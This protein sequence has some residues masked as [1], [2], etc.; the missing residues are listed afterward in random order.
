MA[1]VQKMCFFAKKTK[2]MK[3]NFLPLAILLITGILIS[4]CQNEQTSNNHLYP[5][6]SAMLIYKNTSGKM[7]LGYDT[8]YFDNYG[9]IEVQIRHSPQGREKIIRNKTKIYDVNYKNQIVLYN[10]IQLQPGKNLEESLSITDLLNNDST[11]HKIGTEKILN[12]KCDIY[13]DSTGMIK[14]YVWKNL[15]LKQEQSF[16]NM[17]IT[18]EVIK[19]EKNI[20]FPKGL[21]DYP[22]NFK[23]IDLTNPAVRD[24][25]QQA[26]IQQLMQQMDTNKT[27]N[28]DSLSLLF[29]S[30][31]NS[32]SNK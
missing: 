4:A 25:L 13:T 6:K 2:A 16:L 29:Q 15:I 17:K 21:T 12:R 18:Y 31:P 14:L 8:L 28:Q 7:T 19:L 3:R 10:E 27:D 30:N 1:I 23:F 22:K 24:S 5:Y 9:T 20:S 32:D 11:I 26:Y